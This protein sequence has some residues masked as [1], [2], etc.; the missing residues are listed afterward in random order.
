[1]K[2]FIL[3]RGVTPVGKNR[4]PKMS[5]LAEIMESAGFKQVQTYIQSGNII[6]D[7]DMNDADVSLLVHNLILEK[8]GADLSVIVKN[9][10][11]LEAALAENQCHFTS[12]GYV[13]RF[14]TERRRLQVGA[15]PFGTDLT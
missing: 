2:K 1:M 9:Q 14:L 7:T 11:Q 6:L 12:D 8:I 5:Y 4:I 3:L 15:I 10:M 13:I